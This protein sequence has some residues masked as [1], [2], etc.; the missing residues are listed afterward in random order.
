M[1]I[2]NNKQ[3]NEEMEIESIRKQLDPSKRSINIDHDSLF[4]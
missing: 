2:Y 4:E 1:N 3:L